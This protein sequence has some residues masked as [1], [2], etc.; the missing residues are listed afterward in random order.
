MKRHI[1]YG[2]SL[3]LAQVINLL[4][5]VLF[6]VTLWNYMNNPPVQDFIPYGEILFRKAPFRPGT[7]RPAGNRAFLFDNIV[8]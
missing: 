5:I 8:I 4:G 2:A 7:D 6:K 1:I 3:L